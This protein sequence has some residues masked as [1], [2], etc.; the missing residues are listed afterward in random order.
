MVMP[1]ILE[2]VPSQSDVRDAELA[3]L[4]V[5]ISGWDGNE[6]D[7]LFKAVDNRAAREVVLREYFNARARSLLPAY[8][9]GVD[10]DEIVGRVGMTRNAGETDVALRRRL[11]SWVA[12]IVPLGS[13]AAYNAHARNAN[14][15]IADVGL[16]INAATRTVSV[17]LLTT[18]VENGEPTSATLADVQDYMRNDKRLLFGWTVNVLAPTI[19]AFTITADITYRNG[20]DSAG[21]LT[22]ARSGIN[23]YLRLVHRFGRS[24]YRAAIIGSLL[25]HAD[26]L[27][28]TVS[29]P[30]ADITVAQTDKHTVNY[31][32]IGDVTLTAT[33]EV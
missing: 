16:E 3:R 6:T 20:G 30:S 15:L 27:S 22:A 2:N 19:N 18:E 10:L 1:P 13:E 32:P 8:A 31:C 14:P 4:R 26:A 5:E 29:V 24:V 21:V 33:E 12:Q 7:P 11:A 25:G 23:D 9:T 17:F 28:A